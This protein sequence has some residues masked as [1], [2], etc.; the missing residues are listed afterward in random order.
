MP[1]PGPTYGLPPE[2]LRRW[3]AERIL[4]FATIAASDPGCGSGRSRTFRQRWVPACKA[5]PDPGNAIPVTTTDGHVTLPSQSGIRDDPAPAAA[6]PVSV[7]ARLCG[8]N[9][10]ADDTGRCHEIECGVCEDPKPQNAAFQAS[11]EG[12]A[13]Q[14]DAQNRAALEKVRRQAGSADLS[15]GRDQELHKA[16]A[17]ASSDDARSQD[18]P[19]RQRSMRAK[20]AENA[21]QQAEAAATWMQSV[22]DAADYHV[23]TNRDISF[24][25]GLIAIA[26]SGDRRRARSST[27]PECSASDHQRFDR[28]AHR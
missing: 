26:L 18:R 2:R 5:D 10:R 4:R 13:Q 8:R 14:A 9:D 19:S 24:T 1:D 17:A 15:S 25:G 20:N 16:N 23:N 28:Q 7:L 12:P 11:P 21:G 6:M 22:K 27:R 3:R